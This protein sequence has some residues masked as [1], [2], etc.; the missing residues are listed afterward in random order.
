M[1]FKDR[2]CWYSVL[3]QRPADGVVK[4]EDMELVAIV[5]ETMILSIRVLHNNGISCNLYIANDKNRPFFEDKD[6]PVTANLDDILRNGQKIFFAILLNM[7][8]CVFIICYFVPTKKFP[9]YSPE[10]C[11]GMRLTLHPGHIW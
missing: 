2:S 9:T 1:P 6:I 8:S 7:Q 5:D 11:R 3:G 4:Q 10:M